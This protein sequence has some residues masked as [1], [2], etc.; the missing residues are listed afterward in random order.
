L[1]EHHA[2]IEADEILNAEEICED[3]AKDLDPKVRRRLKKAAAALTDATLVKQLKAKKKHTKVKK[4]VV[5]L[6]K[7]KQK[8]QDMLKTMTRFEALQKTLIEVGKRTAAKKFQKTAEAKM[9][10]GLE[11]SKETAKVLMK[12]K[13]LKSFKS[14]MKSKMKPS[15]K[16]KPSAKAK[17]SLKTKDSAVVK[18]VLKTLLKEKKASLKADGANLKNK[19]LSQIKKDLHK[20][21]LKAKLKCVAG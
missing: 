21:A 3:F 7:G 1:P 9:N 12:S 5:I 18:Q 8:M 15:S 13:F 10:K 6:Q 17:P 2:I 14:K 11:D 19:K 16:S 20:Q 4:W